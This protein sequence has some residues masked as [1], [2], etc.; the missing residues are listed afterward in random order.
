MSTHTSQCRH[1]LDSLSDYVDGSA[2]EALCAEIER[3]LAECENCRVVVDT[4]KKTIYLVR[5]LDDEPA[6]LPADVRTR[7][8]HTLNL[9]TFLEKE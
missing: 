5:A 8:F 1:L 2:Q 3:H 7:L 9:E 6:N 4:L